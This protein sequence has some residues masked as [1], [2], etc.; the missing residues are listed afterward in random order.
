MPNLILKVALLL[1]PP[2]CYSST[3]LTI[4]N[5]RI[6]Q[7]QLNQGAIDRN[8]KR[9][10]QNPAYYKQRQ[11]IIEHQFGTLKRH[12]GFNH[13]LTRG[14][15]KVLSECALILTIYNLRRSLSIL[16]FEVLLKR[17]KALKKLILHLFTTWWILGH[18]AIKSQ[19]IFTL[20]LEGVPE[21]RKVV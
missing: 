3:C 15:Y 20:L 4:T 5:K 2:I 7:R 1:S 6:I 10:T 8:N 18:E 14:K 21:R 16:G 11:Q 17:I 12:W 19:I 9:V 13:L